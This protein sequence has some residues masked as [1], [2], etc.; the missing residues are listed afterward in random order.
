M[1]LKVYNKVSQ[2]KN[3]KAL[4]SKY[5]S[6]KC[7]SYSN[8]T[9]LDIYDIGTYFILPLFSQNYYFAQSCNFLFDH[10]DLSLL[11]RKF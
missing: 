3:K 4:K 9:V 7:W 8:S 6:L 1:S 5:K 2:G 10:I 11:Y